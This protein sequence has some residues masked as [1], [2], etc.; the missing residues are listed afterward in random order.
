MSY[1][2]GLHCAAVE[3]D[4]DSGGVRIERYAIA[5][6][7]GRAVNPT[8]IE[9]Q[10]VGGLAQGAGGA[11]LEHLAYD[12]HGQLVAGSFADLLLPTAAE[13][14]PVEVLVT[15]DAPSPLTPLGFKGAGEGGTSA[16]GAAIASA[17]SDALGT[18]V[19]ALPI[20]PE[21]VLALADAGGGR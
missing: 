1:P 7:V 5:Y 8:L 19:T 20:T 14:P 21:R 10:I 12:D 2:Y 9:G 3:I 13:V 11:L 15:E 4:L 18:E 17:V 16:A 6:D